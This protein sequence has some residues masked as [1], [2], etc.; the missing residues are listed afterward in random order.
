MKDNYTYPVLK[1]T[2]EDYINLYFPAFGKE[3]MISV[4][5]DSNYIRAAQDYLALIIQEYESTK[6]LLPPEDIPVVPEDGQ[7]LFYVNLWMPYHR[8]V[9]KQ[10]YVKKTLTI[11]EWVN[12]LGLQYNLNFSQILTDGILQRLGIYDSDLENLRHRRK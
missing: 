4:G 12:L 8:S 2:D 10:V 1:K 6:K 3:H 5:K 9:T 11:P 7:E